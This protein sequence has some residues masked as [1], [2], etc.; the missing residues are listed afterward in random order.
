[1]RKRV[2]T[3]ATVVMLL[4]GA[5][6]GQDANG[7]SPV[8]KVSANE[9]LPEFDTVDFQ[10]SKEGSQQMEQFLPNG[11]IQFQA[12]P[13]KFMVLAAWGY[14]YDE[15]RV[16]GGPSWMNTEKFDLMAT[17]APDSSIAT[18]RL[19]L[20]AFLVERLGLQTHVEDKVIPVYALLRGNGPLK[21][22]P[23]ATAGV[24]E[25]T[26]GNAE[27]LTTE[28]CHNMKM[29]DLAN[30]LHSMAP[31]YI[32]RPVVNLTE[33]D[34]AYDFELQWT[35]RAQLPTAGGLT[36]FES[37]DRQLGLKLEPAEHS[38]PI[39]VVDKLNRIE[40]GK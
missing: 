34:G 5:A 35:P 38:M 39:I 28:T 26:R 4:S 27:G 18:L 2:S 37:V 22:K 36:V 16:A 31:V 9:K 40:A 30:S 32:D 21:V 19:M 29:D 23:S 1:M 12:L 11:K 25:C 7:Y 33:I 14:G 3:A 24:S 10:I 8:P 13:V 6:F 17:A 20:R 15:S